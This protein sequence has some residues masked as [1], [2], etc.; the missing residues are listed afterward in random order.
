MRSR[1]HLWLLAGFSFVAGPAAAQNPPPP[2]PNVASPH[3]TDKSPAGDSAPVTLSGCV[4]RS[5]PQ[6]SA[7]S[8]SSAAGPQALYALRTAA[9]PGAEATVYPLLPGSD[10]I[11]LADHV[12]HRVQ[13]TAVMRAATNTQPGLS[14][15]G[16]S[17]SMR[18]TGMDTQPRPGAAAN[19]P[20]PAT[21]IAQ[22]LFVNALKMLDVT[23]EGPKS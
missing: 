20:A 23:C 9:A 17:P 15:A 4:E 16:V 6:P 14:N 12:G 21:A 22:P 5:K 2:P 7:S 8:S 18:S 19:E 13:I 3:A 11:K 1:S 10:T